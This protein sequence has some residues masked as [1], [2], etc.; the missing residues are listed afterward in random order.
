MHLKVFSTD[1]IGKHLWR[2][3]QTQIN[4]QNFYR[5]DFNILNPRA[6]VTN[7]GETTIHRFEFPLMQWC[8][9]GV[10][11]VFGESITITR[12]CLF[13][14]GI[15]TVYG[16]F[17]LGNVLFKDSVVAWLLAWAFNFSPL[18]YYYTMNPIPDNLALCGSV[19]GIG[20]LFRYKQ[21]ENLL[22]AVY[23]AVFLMVAVLCKLPFILFYATVGAYLISR[24]VMVGLRNSRKYL[25]AGLV[26]VFFLTPAVAWY[27]W[28]IPSW[29]DHGL[30]K[31]VFGNQITWAKA[32]LILEYHI[33]EILPN[34]LLGIASLLLFIAG[35]F[36]AIKK[37]AYQKSNFW[38]L[39]CSGLAALSYFGFELNMIEGIHDYYM[40]PFLLPVFVLVGYGIKNLW[41]AGGIIKTFSIVV[42]LLMPAQAYLYV[43]NSWSIE[44][45]ACNHDL[46]LYRDALRAAVPA[47]EICIMLNDNS[48]H[49]FPYAVDKRGPVFLDDSLRP[50]WL[51][52]L[53]RRE[54]IQYMYS[55]S[56][57]TDEDPAFVQ[58]FD[59]VLLECGTVR[60]IKLKTVDQ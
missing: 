14:L 50:E 33:I 5:H 35:I 30:L 16:F 43:G 29:G 59:S 56:R 39:A 7:W 26:F 42:L 32:F 41:Y 47:N 36:Y 55:D 18:F 54:K 58:Y 4:I 17:F 15:L 38:L 31:G 22:H 37:K 51:G 10:H 34:R 9:A 28:V 52:D 60:V 53:I 12:I 21:S 48:L 13:L 24:V 44:R 8:I 46:I 45:S 3:S 49:I 40:M 25:L 11:K 57:K 1:L 6:N 27:I 20:W 2:Q 23:S 19:W